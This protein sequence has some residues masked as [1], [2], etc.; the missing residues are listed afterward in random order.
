MLT[1][2]MN[3][4]VVR[5]SYLNALK[6]RKNEDSGQEKY[7][8]QLLIPKTDTETVKAIRECIKNAV[9]ND[10]EGKQYL[11]GIKTPKTPLHDG[12]GEKPNGGEYDAV[13]KGHW[14]MSASSNS[15][16]GL[17]GTERDIE[18]KLVPL[19]DESE[20]YSGVEGRANIN[21]YSYA[22]KGNK[23]VACGLNHL[24]KVRDGEPLGGGAGNANAA[25]DDGFAGEDS[26][27]G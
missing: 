17:V 9:A 13:C 3:T 11:K 14:V 27:F 25:F 15:K 19:T 18:G 2:K 22:N 16:P 4:G 8:V 10:A 6:P 12:D 26:M 20:W 23:G 21:F 1:T 5:F 7:S 24:Q